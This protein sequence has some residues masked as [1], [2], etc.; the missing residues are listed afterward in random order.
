MANADINAKDIDGNTPAHCCSEYGHID[1][2]RFL[3]LHNPSLFSKN[4]DLQSPVDVAVNN[5]IWEV[6][7]LLSVF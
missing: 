4:K 2:L 1:C 3:L 7:F 6:S 5:E